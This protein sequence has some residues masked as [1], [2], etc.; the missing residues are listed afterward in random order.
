MATHTLREV[1]NARPSQLAG[2][3]GTVP[4][5]T[6]LTI[7]QSN[8]AQTGPTGPYV[9][10]RAMVERELVTATPPRAP[11]NANQTSAGKHSS[12]SVPFNILFKHE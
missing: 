3:S 6:N 1:T 5:G 4:S 2:M 11:W 10:S 8:A 12:K 7:F 9:V